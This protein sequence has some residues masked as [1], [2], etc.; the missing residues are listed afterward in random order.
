MGAYA[1]GGRIEAEGGVESRAGISGG[2]EARGGGRLARGGTD[3][4]GARIGGMLASELVGGSEG[5]RT[6]PDGVW[7]AL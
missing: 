1:I 4:D 6:G 7:I 2:R 3:K 5:R